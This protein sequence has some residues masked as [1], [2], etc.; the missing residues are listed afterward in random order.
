VG[1][2]SGATRRGWQNGSTRCQIGVDGAGRYSWRLIA[3]N[4]R[5]VAVSATA[6][7]DHA[8]CRAAFEALCAGHEGVSGGVQHPAAGGS[9]W[10]WLLR[11]AQGG[12]AAVSGRAYERHSTCRAAYER[13]RALL[14]DLASGARSQRPVST[15]YSAHAASVVNSGSV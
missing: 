4:G 5:V 11:D 14:P 2:G 1:V 13:F 15:P 9:G 12:P 3:Q 6:Y 7:G 10:A 8:T